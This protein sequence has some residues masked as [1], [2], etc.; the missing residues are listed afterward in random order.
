MWPLPWP[1][2]QA[3]SSLPPLPLLSHLCLVNE[4]GYSREGQAAEF[5]TKLLEKARNVRKLAIFAS[6][7]PWLARFNTVVPASLELHYASSSDTTDWGSTYTT[8]NKLI[9]RGCFSAANTAS[10]AIITGDV[11]DASYPFPNLRQLTVIVSSS[12]RARENAKKRAASQPFTVKFL[13][14]EVIQGDNERFVNPVKTGGWP[15][16]MQEYLAAVGV[17]LPA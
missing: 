9:L 8:V 16:R 5:L 4:K 2:L 10:F 17:P 12:P 14:A 15:R 7:L 11:A 3:L 1:V 13:G 6:L